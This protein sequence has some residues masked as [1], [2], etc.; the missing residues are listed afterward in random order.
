MAFWDDNVQNVE[1]GE[2]EGV[3]TN[4][5]NTI[6]TNL[7]SQTWKVEEVTLLEKAFV[8]HIFHLRDG[9]DSR[10]DIENRHGLISAIS[11]VSSIVLKGFRNWTNRVIGYGD[12]RRDGFI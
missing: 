10:L 4:R 12:F 6:G 3:Q 7:L 8:I 11:A 5:T 1:D 2:K 9:S